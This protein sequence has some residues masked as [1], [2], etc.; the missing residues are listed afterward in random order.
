[1]R[2]PL[3]RWLLVAVALG[4]PATSFAQGTTS[5]ASG[6][7]PADAAAARALFDEARK[8]EQAGRWG[9]ALGKFRRI[10]QSKE[11][12]SVRFH[13]AY[14]EEKLGQLAGAYRNYE[15][16][17]ELAR[18]TQ[19]PDR[20]LIVEQSA[21]GLKD[22][23][24]RVPEVVVQLPREVEGLRATLDGVELP[25]DRAAGP[26]R[27]DPGQHTLEVAAPGKK[28]FVREFAL[29]ER[30]RHTV[31]VLFEASPSG[32]ASAAS[33]PP[34]P[35]TAPAPSAADRAA[36]AA[37]AGEGGG[38]LAPWLVGGASV[39][40]AGVA[41]GFFFAGRSQGERLD[42]CRASSD[43]ICDE[44]AIKSV[45]TRNYALAAS[46]GALS[47]V[48]AGVTLVLALSGGGGDAPAA[49]AAGGLVIVP[50]GVGWA[51]RF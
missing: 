2:R 7:A 5:P 10:L 37:D 43:V 16:A 18:T 42:E 21:A 36:P 26:L 33:A 27:V 46:A 24:P 3:A 44:S 15:R 28:R 47:L 45:R 1:M 8:D 40:L 20:M 29:A 39:A 17:L 13:A 4:S 51:G 14:C 11:T 23:S 12:A 22:L 19:G 25:A 38:S 31:V 30:E 32:P 35:T 6:A 41:T 9:E 50:G 34:A 49:K 48:G